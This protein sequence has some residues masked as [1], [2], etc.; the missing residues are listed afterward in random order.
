[1]KLAKEN[2]ETMEMK[3]AKGNSKTKKGLFSRKNKN[4]K[5]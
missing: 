5:F 4:N 1:V 3:R 2:E